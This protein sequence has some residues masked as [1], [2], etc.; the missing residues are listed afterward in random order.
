MNARIYIE[1]FGVGILISQHN[2][3]FGA[4]MISPT[5]P[6]TITVFTEGTFSTGC[7]FNNPYVFRLLTHS[8]SFC[9]AIG[10]ARLPAQ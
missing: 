10:Q 2:A 8:Y 5:M 7:D 3:K 1:V 6:L 4:F 9:I